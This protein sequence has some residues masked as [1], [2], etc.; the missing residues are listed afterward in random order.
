MTEPSVFSDTVTKNAMAS[1]QEK[2]DPF[3]MNDLAILFAPDRLIEFFPT[4]DQTL[5]ER[6]NS[7]T[8][9]VIFTSVALSMYQSSSKPM[10]FGAVLLIGLIVMWRNQTVTQSIDTFVPTP[11]VLGN[12]QQMSQDTV[13]DKHKL[14]EDAKPLNLPC[15]MPTLENP[16][17]NPLYGEDPRTP[18]A[19]RGPGVQEMAANFLDQQLRDDPED[20]YGKNQMQRQF[21]TTPVTTVVDDRDKFANWLYRDSANCKQDGSECLYEDLRLSRD[22]FPVDNTDGNTADNAII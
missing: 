9:L 11:Q 12:S 14:L 20:L 6:M 4:Q 1:S 8:R 16:M 17:M 2:G 19:C 5:E 18:E 13:K 22:S 15:R 21:Y 3:F 7:L 10:H